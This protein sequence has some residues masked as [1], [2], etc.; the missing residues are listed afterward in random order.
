[1]PLPGCLW[2]P[3]CPSL[4]GPPHWSLVPT[5]QSLLCAAGLKRRL[6]PASA[7]LLHVC[8]PLCQAPA[9]PTAPPAH[10]TAPPGPRGQMQGR[11]LGAPQR[12]PPGRHLNP[13]SETATQPSR[14]AGSARAG[15]WRGEHQGPEMHRPGV[16]T[17]RRQARGSRAGRALPLCEGRAGPRAVW[18]PGRPLGQ[19]WVSR[20]LGPPLPSTQTPPTLP[21]QCPTPEHPPLP[22]SCLTP[23][24]A[25]D[26]LEVFEPLR[27]Y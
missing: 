18:G 17:Q 25:S 11:R 23:P 4:G 9:L 13:D 20:T 2:T 7:H 3:S 6:S 5:L 1:M 14:A 19:S 16:C 10:T 26:R 15:R 12:L 22:S 27:H 8:G 21:P 24:C